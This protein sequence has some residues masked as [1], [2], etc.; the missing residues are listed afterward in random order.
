[1]I[2]VNKVYCLQLNYDVVV[3]HKIQPICLVKLY[4]IPIDWQKN[5]TFHPVA[6]KFQQVLQCSF[7]SRLQ[8]TSM[9]LAVHLH[10]HTRYVSKELILLIMLFYEIHIFPFID[11]NTALLN[12]Q[13]FL[14]FF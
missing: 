2:V 6:F 3:H 12:P 5:L 7:V 9:I 11:Y 14:R 8:K 1:M 10:R 4:I 13:F